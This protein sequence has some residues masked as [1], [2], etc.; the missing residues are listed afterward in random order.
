LKHEEAMFS[1]GHGIHDVLIT[2]LIYELISDEQF[3]QRQHLLPGISG[4]IPDIHHQLDESCPQCGQSL[5]PVQGYYTPGDPLLERKHPRV[6]RH[7]HVGINRARFAAEDELLFTQE[8]LDADDTGIQFHGRVIA[9]Q[10]RMEQLKT[11]LQG[12]HFIG[13]GRSR[14]YGQVKIGVNPPHQQ[15]ELTTR[16]LTFQNTLTTHLRL[17]AEEYES[18]TFPDKV[19]GTVISLTLRSPAILE[20]YG[21]PH[22]IPKPSTLGLPEAKTIRAWTRPITITGWDAAA[23][24]PRRTRLASK[25]GSVFLYYLPSALDDE[26]K[27]A[28]ETLERY[29]LGAERE[30]GFGQV[31]ICAPIHYQHAKQFGGNHA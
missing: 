6:R 12:E 4:L 19:P 11:F 21:Q 16:I 2:Q 17:W 18:V 30:R 31:E 24:L 13:R 25:A 22:L 26:A 29:G 9:P 15:E 10:A 7:A 23:R 3:P 28:L 8:V 1:D 20:S 27:A 5:V 14:G